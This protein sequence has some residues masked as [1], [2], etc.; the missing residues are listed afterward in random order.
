MTVVTNAIRVALAAT[1]AVSGRSAYLISAVILLFSVSLHVSAQ[2]TTISGTVYDPRTTTSALPLPNVLVYVTTGK[3]AAM[4][5]GVQCLTYS[6]PSGVVSYSYTAVDGSF[7][8]NK[9]PVNASYTLVIQ[10]GKWRRQFTEVVNAAPLTGLNLH[11]PSNHLEGDMP[12][13]AIATGAAD[14]VECVLHDMGVDDSEFTDDNGTTNVGGHVHLYQGSGGSGAVITPATPSDT[15]LTGNVSNLSNYDMVMFPCQGGP[16]I[17]SDAALSNIVNYANAGGRIFTTHFSYVWLDPDSPYNSQFPPVA[18]WNLEFTYLQP[19]PGTATVNTG[20]TDGATMSQWLQ[21][22]GASYNNEPGEVQI[23]TLRHDI[24][25]VIP[26]TQSWL[27]LNDAAD[28]NPVMQFTF[29]TPVSA[30]AANQCGRVLFTEYHV[31]NLDGQGFA[32]PNECPTG[33]MNAQEE[34]L[35]YA[36]FD[37]TA[38]VKPVVVPSLSAAFDPSPLI[39]KQGDSTEVVT[40]SVTNTSTNTAIDPSATLTVSLPS[41]LTAVGINDPTKGWICAL[42]SLK[43]IRTT[44]IGSTVSDPV[45]FTLSVGSS[46]TASLADGSSVIKATISSPT[47]SNDVVVTDPIVFQQK[48]TINW[49]APASIVYGTAL[50]GLQLDATST[51]PGTIVYTPAIGTLLPAGQHTL[52]AVF[53]PSDNASFTPTTATVILT[54]TPFMPVISVSPTPNPAFISNA[55]TITASIPSTAGAPSGTVAFYDGA[56][57]LGSTELSNGTATLATSAL[58]MGHHSITAIYSGDANYQPSGSAAMKETVQDFAI[59]SSGGS[60]TGTPTVYPG[61]PVSYAIVISPL[62][63]TTL[64]GALNLSIEGLPA[65]ATAEFTP[66]VVAANS[67]TTNVVLRVTTPTLAAAETKRNP[68]GDGSVPLALGLVLLPFASRLRK[69]RQRWIPMVLLAIAGAALALGVTGCGGI[70]YTPK[71]FTMTVTATSG[72]LS[73]SSAVKLTVE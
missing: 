29:N 6:A 48:S 69:A 17:Q 25:G 23:S 54:V 11:M 2:S 21:N 43:C 33:P 4:P 68:L 22:A 3:V 16:Y 41:G 27:A 1:R 73:H 72:N 39:V 63:G 37:L 50:S 7:T 20:F 19:D 8:V 5:S 57:Q 44:S 67:G 30:P 62:G 34:M 36:L 55:V 12:M 46:P 56:T 66:A 26:P 10:A 13:I 47:F 52:T 42:N 60:P 64:A 9:V 61:S 32:Y 45:T 70:T 53:T 18:N 40:I 49:P 59:A 51:D 58:A 65:N 35:E 28:G 14:G 24:D 15:T 71:N 38:F 31:K